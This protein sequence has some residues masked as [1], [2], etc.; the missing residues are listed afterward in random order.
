MGLREIVKIYVRTTNYLY[1][2]KLYTISLKIYINF[3][4]KNNWKNCKNNIN[5]N[6]LTIEIL[7]KKSFDN[8]KNYLNY[9][10]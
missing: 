2:F 9:T 1:Y 7:T 4:I 8:N 6:L 5:F 3:F 10:K